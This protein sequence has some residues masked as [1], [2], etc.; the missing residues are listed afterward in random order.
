VHDVRRFAPDECASD[1]LGQFPKRHK[2]QLTLNN[3]MRRHCFGPQH[4]AAF[5]KIPNHP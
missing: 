5:A 2:P 3:H 1:L 4:F